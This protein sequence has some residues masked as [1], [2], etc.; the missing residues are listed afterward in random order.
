MSRRMRIP[1]LL[2]LLALAAPALAA[3]PHTVTEIVFDSALWQRVREPATF[4]YRYRLD[5]PTLPAPHFEKARMEVREVRADGEKLVYFDLFEGPNHRAFGPVP[6]RDVNPMILVFLQKDVAGMHNLTGG[7]QGY[8]QQQIRRA[9]NRPAEVERIRIRFDGREIGATRVRIRPF[10]RDPNIARFPQFRDKS[11][12]F[13]VSDA[14]PGGLYRIL[15][16]TPDPEGRT[17]IEESL[18]FER[19]SP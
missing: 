3:T 6:A 15:I 4:H 19:L 16:R 1:L 11:Y 10:A 13:T 5:G 18:T 14:I 8:F 9:F 12:E 17:V 7:A 2:T